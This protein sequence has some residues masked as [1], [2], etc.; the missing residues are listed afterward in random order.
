MTAGPTANLE[1]VHLINENAD[2]VGYHMSNMTSNIEGIA[3][4]YGEHTRQGQQMMANAM[5]P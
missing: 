4:Q 5:T 3:A 1:A 2:I